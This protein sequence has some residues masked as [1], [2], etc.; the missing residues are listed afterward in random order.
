MEGEAN[1]NES[2]ESTKRS[3]GDFGEKDADITDSIVGALMKQIGDF[4]G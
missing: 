1:E 4:E 3:V 2:K